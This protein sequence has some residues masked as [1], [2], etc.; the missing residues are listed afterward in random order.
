MFWAQTVRLVKHV[1]TTDASIL[2]P[3]FALLVRSVELL[4]TRPSVTVLPVTPE[5]VLIVASRSRLSVRLKSICITCLAEFA[6]AGVDVLFWSSLLNFIEFK[7]EN[8]SCFFF[9]FT[10][11]LLLLL[12]LLEA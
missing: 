4:I 2:A 3:E 8:K 5:T 7:T 6:F 9:F 11:A 1:S 12:V 10:T